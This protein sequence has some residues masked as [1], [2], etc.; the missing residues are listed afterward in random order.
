[1]SLIFYENGIEYIVERYYEDPGYAFTNGISDDAGARFVGPA[2]GLIFYDRGSYG[3][4]ATGP[5]SEANGGLPWRYLELS[6]IYTDSETGGST[7]GFM[8]WG[9]GDILTGATAGADGYNASGAP[10]A[11][12]HDGSG[13]SNSY[14]MWAVNQNR[15]YYSAYDALE[16]T[17]S[18]VY[19]F[20]LHAGGYSD[21]YLPSAGEYYYIW[22][23]LVSNRAGSNFGR[24][25][26]TALSGT[27]FASGTYW[28]STEDSLT[29]A[30]RQYFGEGFQDA[31]TKNNITRVRAVRRF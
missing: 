15:S 5:F 16:A 31:I 26:N 2:G 19:C 30:W 3:Y 20:G 9:R 6:P 22:W 29:T 27:G 4:D 24:G 12:T 8:R 11:L 25:S 28:S 7:A 18:I 10:V 14:K 1:M 13:L 17:N 21:W 23:N